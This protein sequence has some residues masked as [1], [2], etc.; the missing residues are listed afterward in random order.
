VPLENIDGTK[1]FSVIFRFSDLKPKSFTGEFARL[2][3]NKAWVGF[4]PRPF[5]A[6][7]QY[8]DYWTYDIDPKPVENATFSLT[9]VQD[10]NDQE[11]SLYRNDVLI[12]STQ[13]VVPPGDLGYKKVSTRRLQV[14]F[15]H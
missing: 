4:H 12:N 13:L 3:C 1:S 5:C 15:T 11:V 9:F 7:K 6:R 2:G 8:G 10:A 14:Y